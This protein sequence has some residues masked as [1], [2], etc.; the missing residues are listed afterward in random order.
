M[1]RT[2]ARTGGARE[3]KRDARAAWQGQPLEGQRAGLRH[4]DPR[5]GRAAPAF[6][7]LTLSWP[8]ILA[9]LGRKTLRFFPTAAPSPMLL[10]I[11]HHGEMAME[12]MRPEPVHEHRQTMLLIFAQSRIKRRRCVRD[13]FEILAPR[14]RVFAAQPQ[15]VDETCGN[16]RVL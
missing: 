12:K 5:P 6:K 7:I 2:P 14:H 1:L 15:S 9:S 16:R 8:G 13:R 11:A 3:P 10:A 4:V